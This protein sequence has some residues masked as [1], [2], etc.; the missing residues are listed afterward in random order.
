MRPDKRACCLLLRKQPRPQGSVPFVFP[1]V[2]V[3]SKPSPG[4][5]SHKLVVKLLAGS[6]VDGLRSRSQRFVMGLDNSI[7]HEP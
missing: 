2:F 6:V 4:D 5:V 7:A 3:V 1:F